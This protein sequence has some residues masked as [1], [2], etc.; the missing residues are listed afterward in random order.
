[1]NAYRWDELVVGQQAQFAATVSESDMSAFS[2]VSGDRNP[3]HLDEDFA[4]SAGFPGRVVFGLLSSS[5]YSRLVGHHLPGR[6][7]LLHGLDIDLKAP[8]FIGDALVVSGRIEHLNDAYRRLE[9]KASIVNA[10]GRTVSKATI[11]AGV[12]EPA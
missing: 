6:Y 11:R 2:A 1:M 9:I 12:H 10:Q 8:V 4:R 5:F 3:L 7:A